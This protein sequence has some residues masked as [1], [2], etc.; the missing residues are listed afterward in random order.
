M[1]HSFNVLILGADVFSLVQSS[2]MM[3]SKVFF[4]VHG[5][6]LLAQES[7]LY[8]QA[9]SSFSFEFS[10]SFLE[11]FFEIFSFNLNVSLF[12]VVIGVS[13]CLFSL[14]VSSHALLSRVLRKFYVFQF[15]KKHMGLRTFSAFK[16]YNLC[17][18]QFFN[19]NDWLEILV[20]FLS[21]KIFVWIFQFGICNRRWSN[22]FMRQLLLKALKDILQYTL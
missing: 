11:F 15:F 14:V 5:G 6:L 12:L 16:Q 22:K 4:L 3:L 8:L 2:K 21:N 10:V 7:K 17:F 1:L 9:K 13:D 20:T 19:P 18:C